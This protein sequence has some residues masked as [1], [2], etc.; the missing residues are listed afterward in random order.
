MLSIMVE[1]RYICMSLCISHTSQKWAAVPWVGSGRRSV[2]SYWDVEGW[3]VP[4]RPP[5]VTWSWQFDTLADAQLDLVRDHK[6]LGQKCLMGWNNSG[7]KVCTSH[8]F[9]QS[10][11]TATLRPWCYVTPIYQTGHW[12]LISFWTLPKDA[13]SKRWHFEHNLGSLASR[14][15]T[16]RSGRLECRQRKSQGTDLW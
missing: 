5:R 12:G 15:L 11:L 10:V 8:W 1:D 7:N 14:A 2:V 13:A 16:P 4:L 6:W 3:P 9:T